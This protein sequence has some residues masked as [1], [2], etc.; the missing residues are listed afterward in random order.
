MLEMDCRDILIPAALEKQITDQNASRIKARII[1]EAANGPV[2]PAAEEILLKKG[3]MI[4]PDIYIN[5][6]GVTVSAYFEWLKK[7]L[8]FARSFRAGWR[9][10]LMASKTNAT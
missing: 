3:V 2:T 8:S 1:A 10:G 4:V 6:G 5:A 7:M 9:K